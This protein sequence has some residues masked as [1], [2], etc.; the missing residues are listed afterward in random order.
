MAEERMRTETLQSE[1]EEAL[2]KAREEQ[3]D[4]ERGPDW[5][6]EHLR[7]GM[8]TAWA[9]GYNDAHRGD[10]TYEVGVLLGNGAVSTK[11]FMATE[12]EKSED[13]MIFTL[14]VAEQGP[15][16]TDIDDVEVFRVR[17]DHIAWIARSSSLDRM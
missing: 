2:R 12:H 6:V 13:F 17:I 5:F 14:T 7:G 11:R 8:E 10:F 1:F 15:D 4:P 9:V 16:S 3:S